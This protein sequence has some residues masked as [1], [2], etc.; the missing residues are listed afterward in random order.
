MQATKVCW[1]QEARTKYSLQKYAPKKIWMAILS[2]IGTL[3]R[4]FCAIFVNIVSVEFYQIDGSYFFNHYKSSQG[5]SWSLDIMDRF[6]G[7][8]GYFHMGF[9]ALMKFLF[10]GC[11]Q[12]SGSWH[13]SC[14]LFNKEYK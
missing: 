4:S 13:D 7:R 5:F 10:G 11:V 3:F 9:W 6:R 2:Y 14:G 12:V 8:F 1:K